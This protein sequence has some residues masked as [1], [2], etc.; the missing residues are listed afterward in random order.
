VSY[1]E[2]LEEKLTHWVKTLSGLFLWLSS[3]FTTSSL[4]LV[5]FYFGIW[6]LRQYKQAHAQDYHIEQIGIFG[7]Y[8]RGEARSHSD[9]DVVVR[10]SRPNLFH[11]SA[12]ILD[13]KEHFKTEV[14]VVALGE[15]MNTRLKKR[16]GRDAVYA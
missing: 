13:L 15:Q 1:Y 9:I 12:I 5:L 7:S 4:I 6:D 14:D 10:M 2:P 8:A 11:L 16:I 3:Y